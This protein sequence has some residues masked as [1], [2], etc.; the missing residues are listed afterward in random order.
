MEQLSSSIMK[1]KEWR[2]AG[3]EVTDLSASLV[4]L[5]VHALR[6]VYQIPGIRH[7][8]WTWTCFINTIE[9]ILTIADRASRRMLPGSGPNLPS[10]PELHFHL[11]FSTTAQERSGCWMPVSDII[12][13]MAT[14]STSSS[15]NLSTQTAT[16]LHHVFHFQTSVPC[17]W[18]LII[19]F[20][21]RLH[22]YDCKKVRY[23]LKYQT[24]LIEFW[25][26]KA[27]SRFSTA[28][29]DFMNLSLF[30]RL[31]SKMYWMH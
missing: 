10:T 23:L 26:I 21:L 2:G 4:F 19:R 9:L 5:T 6:E 29:F 31:N 28:Y 22:K 3:S 14:T 16:G 13:E 18:S 20:D 7:E 25:L 12:R 30:G 17:C 15:T 24:E 1:T 27:I 8:W 11:S